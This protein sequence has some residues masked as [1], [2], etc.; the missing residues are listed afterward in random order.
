MS[1][2]PRGKARFYNK[3]RIDDY[4]KKI[5][6][7]YND[8]LRFWKREKQYQYIDLEKLNREGEQ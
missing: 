8:N 4:T 1:T 2:L 5:I 6:G 7:F 3:L